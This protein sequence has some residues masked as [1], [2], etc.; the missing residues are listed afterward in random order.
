MTTGKQ[1]TLTPRLVFKL[2]IALSGL[3]IG[4]AFCF[5]VITNYYSNQHHQATQQE[6]HAPLAQH[7]IEEKFAT[8]SAFNQDGSVNKEVF[9]SLMHDMMAVNRSIEVYLLGLDGEVLYS[10]VLD[11]SPGEPSRYVD[12]APIENFVNTNGKNYCLGDDPRAMGERKIFSAARLTNQLKDGYIYIILSGEAYQLASNNIFQKYIKSFGLG[13]IGLTTF[14]TLLV[15]FVSIW[16]LTKNLRKITSV[17]QRF[18]EGDFN[19]RIENA[20]KSD[21]SVL[22]NT[23]NTMADTICQN[24]EEVK[25]VDSLRR[26]L[27]ANVSHDLRTPLAILKG[28][29]ETLLEKKHLLSEGEKQKYLEIVNS[30]SDKLSRL[31]EQLFE[32]SKL[33]AKQ[34]KPEKVKFSI[35]DL[36]L[37]LVS[38]YQLKSKTENIDLIFNI[39][40]KENILVYADIGLIERVL[41]NLIDNAFKFTKA[42]GIIT[43][44]L[45]KSKSQNKIKISVGDS[46]IGIKE[47]DQL[48][49]FDRFTQ[50]DSQ[51]RFT[52]AGIGLSIVKKILELHDSIIRVDSKIGKGTKFTF[53]LQM[54]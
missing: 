23:F 12:V 7:L 3:I 42:G 49:I 1:S 6:I 4:M 2:W 31:V 5:I 16:F 13:A 29:S 10:V 39:E 21:I 46:G 53:H 52:G 43:L 34:V 33:E 41:Q 20:D 24:I 19:A 26:Q 45:D 35:T 27:I 14:F 38:K 50:N 11:H 47:S 36:C 32:Y 22:A 48:M 37:D 9:G 25:K 51:N 18:K 8:T 44:D 30:N 28:Y 17:V 40:K 54:N 15:G